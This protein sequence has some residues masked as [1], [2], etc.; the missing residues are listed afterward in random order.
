MSTRKRRETPPGA[1]K[2]RRLTEEKRITIETLRKEGGA[3]HMAERAGCHPTT[4]WREL[5]RNAGRKGCRHGKAQG[6]ASRRVA[7]KAARRRR[8]TPEMWELAMGFLK[9]LAFDIIRNLALSGISDA[10]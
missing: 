8:F 3:R 1:P 5:R 4:V 6:K 2:Y 9:T 10:A 7:E